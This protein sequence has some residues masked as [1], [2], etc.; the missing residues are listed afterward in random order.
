MKVTAFA[1]ASAPSS[2]SVATAAFATR[3]AFVTKGAGI[4]TAASACLMLNMNGH[5]AGCQCGACGGHSAGCQCGA[6]G[7]SHDA[8]CDCA[9][10][11]SHSLGCSCGSCTSNGPFASILKVR[12]LVK[13]ILHTHGVH[14]CNT[15]ITSNKAHHNLLNIFVT[16][17]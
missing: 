2:A 16:S 9:S 4:A 1:P 12:V 15:W 13:I 10:C 6:C 11:G 3:R 17:Q 14:M 7:G 5:S 8:G